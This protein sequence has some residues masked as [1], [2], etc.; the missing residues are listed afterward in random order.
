[1]VAAGYEVKKVQHNLQL[2]L[3]A[4][5][6]EEFFFKIFF[7]S[8]SGTRECVARAL[9]FGTQTLVLS[10]QE[11]TARLD[12]GCV[13]SAMSPW[14]G[15]VWQLRHEEGEEETHKLSPSV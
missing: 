13:Y 11:C 1:M 2:R 9:D 3:L 7:T 5:C 8:E 4:K 12:Q 14:E 6:L 15:S 10:H